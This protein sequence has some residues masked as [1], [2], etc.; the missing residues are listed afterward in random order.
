MLC[1]VLVTAAFNPE[2][3]WLALPI[4][5][6]AVLSAAPSFLIMRW[7]WHRQ[8][9]KS[10]LADTEMTADIDERGVTLAAHSDRKT[11]LWA[12][13]SQIYESRS[14]VMLE[15]GDSDYLFL[16]KRAMSGAQLAELKRF[17]DLAPNCKVK[18]TSPMS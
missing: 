17:A 2:K 13:F 14:V 5:L 10:Q 3:W 4:S 1:I 9:L 12:G 16:P 8:F 18:L 15:K 11:H 7:R 6:I